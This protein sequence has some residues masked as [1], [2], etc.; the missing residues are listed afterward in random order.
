MPRKPRPVVERFWPKVKKA[1]ANDC[2]L[3]TAATADFGYG[4]IGAGARGTGLIRAHRLSWE[5]AN[6][7]IPDGLFVLHK[8]DVPACVN[9][10]HLF[11]GTLEENNADMTAKGR[12]VNPPDSRGEINGNGKLTVA[13]VLEIRALAGTRTL[14]EISAMFGIGQSQA[15]RIISRE[16]WSHVP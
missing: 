6:G 8:C 1:G 7:A 5:I 14:K 13:N 11:L 15:H 3:W 10:A 2:W 16:S 4:V 12:R 9:P